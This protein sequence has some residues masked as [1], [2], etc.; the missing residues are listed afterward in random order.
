[1]SCVREHGANDGERK[2]GRFRDTM[3]RS[4]VRALPG[5]VESYSDV[6]LR[7]ARVVILIVYV[8]AARQITSALATRSRA[9]SATGVF[10]RRKR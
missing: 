4:G 9:R 2:A 6:I 10:E 5:P 1:M 3:P 8:E 7:L